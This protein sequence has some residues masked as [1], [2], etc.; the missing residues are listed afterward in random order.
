MKS[1]KYGYRGA[2]QAKELVA[3]IGGLFAG[4]E[5]SEADKECCYACITTDLLGCKGRK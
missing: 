2:K 3:Q 5:L 4:G 1:Q